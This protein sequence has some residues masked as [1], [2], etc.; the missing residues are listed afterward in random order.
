LANLFQLLRPGGLLRAT[1][2]RRETQDLFWLED[3]LYDT[4]TGRLY[5]ASKLHDSLHLP[6]MGERKTSSGRRAFYRVQ[7]YYTE[8]E[9]RK[10]LSAAGLQVESLEAIRFPIEFVLQRW[11]SPAHH[12]VLTPRR[13]RCWRDGVVTQMLTMLSRGGR[14]LRHSQSARKLQFTQLGKSGR[15]PG[16]TRLHGRWRCVRTSMHALRRRST[17]TARPCLRKQRC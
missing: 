13:R 5:T 3:E 11:S 16:H 1:V 6:P 4:R 9:A 15:W 14:G 10:L 17:P 12:T 7:Q 2:I 8:F